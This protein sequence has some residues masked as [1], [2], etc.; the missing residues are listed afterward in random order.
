MISDIV[1]FEYLSDKLESALRLGYE[2]SCSGLC[3]IMSR[4]AGVHFELLIKFC[5]VC[6][7]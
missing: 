2:V 3:G 7:P 6:W 1:A 5:K 4:P